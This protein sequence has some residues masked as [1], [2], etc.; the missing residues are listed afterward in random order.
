MMTTTKRTQPAKSLRLMVSKHIFL[1][2]E[3]H[4]P[5]TWFDRC[6]LSCILD[7]LTKYMEK[8][9]LATRWAGYAWKLEHSWN[10]FWK[11]PRLEMKGNYPHFVLKLYTK[12]GATSSKFGWVGRS[13]ASW[14]REIYLFPSTDLF[15]SV[16]LGIQGRLKG[17]KVWFYLFYFFFKWTS[18]GLGFVDVLVVVAIVRSLTGLR[19]GMVDLSALN[20]HLAK[21]RWA[22]EARKTVGVSQTFGGKHPAQETF[23]RVGFL[24]LNWRNEMLVKTRNL[25]HIARHCWLLQGEGGCSP[26]K[27]QT[28]HVLSCYSKFVYLFVFWVGLSGWSVLGSGTVGGRGVETWHTSL[29][30]MFMLLICLFMWRC[31]NASELRFN[32]SQTSS[33]KPQRES[34]TISLQA[35]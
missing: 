5:S 33:L 20:N 3:L 28:R 11:F 13:G 18:S 10:N 21:A 31:Y 12:R 7:C 35:W 2:V 29:M 14:R 15:W 30:T 8:R 27:L 9:H 32:N 16:A 24:G 1:Q 34:H 26:G 6:I 23:D 4:Q 25:G 22:S 19:L 17:L